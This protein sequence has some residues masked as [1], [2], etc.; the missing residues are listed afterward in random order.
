MFTVRYY[1]DGLMDEVVIFEGTL[2]ECL[3]VL[4]E[5]ADDNQEDTF[6]VE[7]DGFTVYGE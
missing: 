5:T 4:A 2:D 6:I 7:P 1:D 3:A